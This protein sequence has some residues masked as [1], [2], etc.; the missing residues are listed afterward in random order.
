MKDFSDSW[1]LEVR[2]NIGRCIWKTNEQG[3]PNFSGLKIDSQVATD[4]DRQEF[5]DILTSSITSTL[6]NSRYAKN[7]RLFQKCITDSLR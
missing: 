5:I 4:N 3:I 7:Y 6:Q 1:S 2:K